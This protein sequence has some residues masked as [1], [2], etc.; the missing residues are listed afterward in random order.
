MVGLRFVEESGQAVR[1]PSIRC[2]HS[3]CPI[4]LPLPSGHKTPGL[5][6]PLPRSQAGDEISRTVVDNK[7]LVP[8]HLEVSEGPVFVHL[9]P[10]SFRDTQN[11]S[12]P[13]AT[14]PL[15]TSP[16]SMWVHMCPLTGEEQDSG[17]V[18][19]GWGERD[20]GER[21]G[22][23]RQA[24][25]RDRVKC[26]LPAPLKWLPAPQQHCLP[27]LICILRVRSFALC[28]SLDGTGDISARNMSAGLGRRLI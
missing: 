3:T 12:F 16:L 2:S 22:V 13:S 25:S 17:I 27:L 23:S 24:G 18:P 20:L 19:L 26:S 8:K 1:I 6:L 11:D 9:L 28:K 5:P 15:G 21:A 7:V 14:A 4:S 10:Q